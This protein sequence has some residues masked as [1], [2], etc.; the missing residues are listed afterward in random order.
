MAHRTPTRTKKV[1]DEKV[2]TLLSTTIEIHRNGYIYI[3]TSN[4]TKNMDVY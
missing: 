1:G 3:Y 2:A 4:E